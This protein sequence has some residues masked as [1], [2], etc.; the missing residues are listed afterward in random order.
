MSA[1]GQRM[2]CLTGCMKRRFNRWIKSSLGEKLRKL[3][4]LLAEAVF[5]RRR[6]EGIQAR[7][8]ELAGRAEALSATRVLHQKQHHRKVKQMKI[9]DVPQSGKCGVAVSI[10]GRYG[11]GRRSLAIPGNPRSTDQLDVRARL[12]NFSKSWPGLTQVQRNA[13]IAAAKTHNSTARLGQSG[14]LTG[15]QLFVQVNCNLALLGAA[16]VPVPPVP[17]IFPALV[18]STLEATN[19]AGVVSLKM[20]CADDPTEYTILRASAPLSAGRSVCREFRVLG[21]CPAPAQ[22]KADI[23]SLYVAKYGAPSAGRRSEVSDR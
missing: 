21:A 23:T 5:L 1:L 19:V 16:S 14:A 8:N 18:P 4:K 13:W 12:T 6:V 10:P 2:S 3:F 20:A 17:V 9:L 7:A 15:S 11:Q 22:G